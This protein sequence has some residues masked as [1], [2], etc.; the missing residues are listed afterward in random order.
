MCVLSESGFK[1]RVTIVDLY[2]TFPHH[3]TESSLEDSGFRVEIRTW[4]ENVPI[5]GDVAHGGQLRE[6]ALM[7][8]S[9]ID[10]RLTP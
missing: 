4:R 2:R 5:G 1:R 7:S 8:S 6:S 3:P 10:I 9:L